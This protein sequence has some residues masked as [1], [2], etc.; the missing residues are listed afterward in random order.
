MTSREQF[1]LVWK[2]SEISDDETLKQIAWAFWKASREVVEIQLPDSR[3]YEET[4]SDHELGFNT[5][6]EQCAEAIRA[7]G[8]KV[9]E[10][11]Q[12]NG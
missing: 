12:K 8:I 11:E 3:D 9:I 4:L 7:A 5:A 2:G 10:G 1:E 6:L